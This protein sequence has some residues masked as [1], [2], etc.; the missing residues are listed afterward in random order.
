MSA[1]ATK[2]Q[3]TS[4]FPSQPPVQPA[5]G[6]TKATA[7]FLAI[8]VSVATSTASV[9]AYDRYFAQKVVAVDIKSFIEE[10][11]ADYV[12]G[13]LDDAGMKREMDKLE[14]A[15]ASIP[16]NRAVL[17]GDLVVKNVEIIKP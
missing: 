8:V 2:A 12:A 17:M 10:K 14:A 9:V 16:K 5:C 6:V 15:V 11:K 4:S 7:V 1:E 13:R 3:A